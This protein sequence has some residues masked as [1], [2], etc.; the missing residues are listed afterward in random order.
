VGRTTRLMALGLVAL[1][2]GSMAAWAQTIEKEE[3]DTALTGEI[4]LIDTKARTVALQGANGERAVVRIDDK[5]TIMSGAKK[6][7]LEGLHKGARV[8]VDADRHGDSLVATYIE[9]VEGP[10]D[11]GSP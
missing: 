7:G 5:T 8:A 6:I 1:C 3:V 4:T 9:V 2:V 11:T 10:T